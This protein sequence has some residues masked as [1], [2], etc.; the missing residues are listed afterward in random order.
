V[1]IRDD[2]IRVVVFQGSKKSALAG[3]LDVW[4]VVQDG[5][6]HSLTPFELHSHYSIA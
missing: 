5:W 6:G 2:G 4:L 3:A 1:R